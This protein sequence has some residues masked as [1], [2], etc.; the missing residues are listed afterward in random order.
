M[1]HRIISMF[2]MF[3]GF[4]VIL[5]LTLNMI[6]GKFWLA[7]FRVY[8]CAARQF[9]AGGQVYLV[10]FNEGSGFFKYSPAILYF[11]L[12]C[13][14]F[15]YKIASV[16]HFLILGI[17]YWYA[18]IVIRNLLKKYIYT[19]PLRKEQ[20]LLPLAFLCIAIHFARE[21]Y[22]G[23]INIVMLLFC[24]LAISDY[25]DGREY[26]G[27]LFLGLAILTKP[28]FLILLLPLLLRKQWKSLSGLAV[29][30][31]AGFLVPFVYPGPGKA[32][33]LFSEWFQAISLHDKGYIDF[34]SLD[35]LARH[36]LFPSLPWYSGY[37]ILLAACGLVAWMILANL[38][39]EK[40]EAGDGGQVPRNILF[41]WFLLLALLPSLIKTDWVVYLLSAPL[42]TFMI[43][44][45][46][47][48]KR[49]MLI[50][51]MVLLLFFFSANSHDLLGR[52][53]SMRL[54]EM[55][56]MGLSNIIL[57]LLA[58]GMFQTG[59]RTEKIS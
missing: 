44:F 4:A 47:G 30:L 56:V 53:L 34:N 18:F 31:L 29:V 3:A 38:K 16:I 17:S 52:E 58:F 23:N 1:K 2:T 35:Y 19:M 55:G 11:F 20:L 54:L 45:I 21:M 26:R 13:T 59:S 5:T 6:N 42:I 24:C 7:D 37:V 48:S 39:R 46:S 57:I 12:P 28:Y 14:I 40:A 25:F 43:Y 36:Y 33:V 41:E 27:S 15:S 22:L 10:S 9:I 32:M 50:P 8:Y 49:Y 51:L